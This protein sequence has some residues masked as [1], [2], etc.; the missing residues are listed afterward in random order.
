[1]KESWAVKGF[2][3]VMQGFHMERPRYFLRHRAARISVWKESGSV[4]LVCVKGLLPCSE[5]SLQS[6]ENIN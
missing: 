5:S 1:M 2:L 6:C 4:R 3:N